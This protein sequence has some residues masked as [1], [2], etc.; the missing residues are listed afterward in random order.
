MSV[1]MAR[2]REREQA[3]GLGYLG[4]RLRLE[5][6]RHVGSLATVDQDKG[7]NVGTKEP[8]ENESRSRIGLPETKTSDLGWT[9]SVEVGSRPLRLKGMDA[10][11]R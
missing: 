1:S 6:G 2:K 3:A 9:T 4:V 5:Q 11:R 10:R 7:D 8:G